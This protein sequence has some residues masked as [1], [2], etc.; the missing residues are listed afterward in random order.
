M[1]IADW[2]PIT[3]EAAKGDPFMTYIASKRFS[4][5]EVQKFAEEHPE[6]DVT[7]C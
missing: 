3:I 6:M 7:A 5:W 1:S 2:F 4:D